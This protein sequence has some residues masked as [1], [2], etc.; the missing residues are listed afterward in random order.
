MSG[1]S[2]VYAVAADAPWLTA[3]RNGDGSLQVVASCQGV[4]GDAAGTILLTAAG[5]QPVHIPA[6]LEFGDE[7]V[8]LPVVLRA[9]RQP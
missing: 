7:R 6:Q 2:A 3:M 9:L 1:L 4:P 5:R 8:Y